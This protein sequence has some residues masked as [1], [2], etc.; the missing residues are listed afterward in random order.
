[1]AFLDSPASRPALHVPGATFGL[2]RLLA[3]M[4]AQLFRSSLDG[5][6]AAGANPCGSLALAHRAARL[7]SGKRRAKLAASIEG[8]LAAA[9]RPSAALSSA[10]EPQRDEIIR[11]APLLIEVCEL[12]RS[13]RPV[14]SQGVAMLTRL[15]HDGGSPVYAPTTPGALNH[16]LRR[17]IA[18]LEG[19]EKPA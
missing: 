15:L 10:V 7:T 2:R 19:R 6:L 17:I 12:L 18:A 14:Y 3:R 4:Q 16:E 11:A 13:T 9:L 8:V 5:A 1:V